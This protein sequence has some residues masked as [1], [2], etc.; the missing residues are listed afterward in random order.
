MVEQLL[1]EQPAANAEQKVNSTPILIYVPGLGEST[2]NTADAVAEALRFSLDPQRAETYKTVNAAGVPAP[3]G[4]T[5]SKTIVDGDDV[6]VLQLFEFAY[7]KTLSPQASSAVPAVV[8]GAVKSS[9]YALRGL[10]MLVPALTRPAKQLKTKFQ[11]S[12]G[13]AACAALVFVAVGALLA[14]VAGL[15]VGMPAWLKGIFGETAA[16]WRWALPAIGVTV[17]WAAFRTALL[18]IAAATQACV[19]FVDN[20]EVVADSIAEQLN[21]ALDG[22][23][24]SGWKGPVHLV[25]YSFGSLVLFE[26]MFPRTTA[27]RGYAPPAK[28]ASLVTI[29]CPLDVVRLFRPRYVANREARDQALGWANVFNEADIFAS[30]LTDSD[31]QSQGIG[32]VT[33]GAVQPESVRYTDQKISFLQI[34]SSGKTHS[35]YWATGRA[36]CFGTLVPIFVPK[37][38]AE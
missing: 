30:N 18:G 33:V 34:L 15:G 5:V 20:D 8:P 31:D 17:T 38:P 7:G 14:L 28:I 21:Q 9:L 11:L 6:A 19:R 27:L 29:G 26:T 1:V 36:S 13:I 22:L 2:D 23:V 16:D 4:L 12:L 35:G 10:L 37:P 25:G 3:T 24:P 32:T